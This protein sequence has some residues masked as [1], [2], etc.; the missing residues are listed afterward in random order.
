M[1]EGVMSGVWHEMLLLAKLV[2]GH[3]GP[4]PPSCCPQAGLDIP[5]STGH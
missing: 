2:E 4:C 1:K 3:R 5:L